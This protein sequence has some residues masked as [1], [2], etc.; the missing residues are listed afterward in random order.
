[1]PTTPT[2]QLD[3]YPV[4]DHHCHPWRA[5]GSPFSVGEYRMLFTEGDDPRLAPDVPATT[6]YR[7]TMR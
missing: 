7:W 2:I 6:Y 5:M 3:A 1:M 4:V